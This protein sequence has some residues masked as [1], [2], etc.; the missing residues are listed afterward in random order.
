MTP[1]E[2]RRQRAKLIADARALLDKAK[3]ENRDLTAEEDAQYSAMLDDAEKLRGQ[4]EREERQQELE[5]GLGDSI[6]EPHRPE[7]EGGALAPDAR[8]RAFRRFIQSGLRS[9]GGEELRALQ[10]DVDTAGGYITAPQQF[11]NE[12]LKGVDN[13][14]FVRQYARVFPLASAESLGVPVLDSDP[15]DPIW[16]SELGTG[17]EDSDMDFGKRE[18]RPHP[19][20][21]RIKVSRTLLR[22]S[23]LPVEQIVRERLAY[24]FGTVMENNYLNGNGAGRPMGV[25]TAASAGMGITT[26]RDVSTGNTTTSIQT[27]GLI[28]AKFSL[29]A[30]YWPRARWTFHRDAVKQIAKLKDGEGRYLLIPSVSGG[31][32][33]N[34][35]DLPFDISE[36]AP[37]TFT[38]GLYVGLL[39][40][41]SYYWIVEALDLQIQRLDELYAETNQVGFIG[42]YEGDG[43]PVL[44]EA[45]TR[46]KLA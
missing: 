22:K 20:A 3:A 14:V 38:T 41:W 30:Q 6:R 35:L 26:A 27:D 8:D 40:D 25:F 44:E 4:Y 2:M 43:M 16:T 29:R 34:L 5:R 42:R 39:C 24:K 15:A 11:V 31:M 12:L 18:L 21:K 37:N 45:F 9:L 23:T 17:D 19:L 10:A 7:V 13:M 28:E 36:Y 32:S 46:V 33:D 1:L